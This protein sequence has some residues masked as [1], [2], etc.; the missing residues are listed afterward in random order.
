MKKNSRI[1]IHAGVNL[2]VAPMPEL[3][4]EARLSFMRRLEEIG[5]KITDTKF[6]DQKLVF[7]RRGQMPL[8]ITVGL[9]GPQFG[10]L[11]VVAPQLGNRSLDI[12]CEEAEDIAGI[13]SNIYPQRQILS[14]DATIRDLYDS[15]SEHAFKE[16]WETRLHQTPESLSAFGRPVLGGGLRFVMPSAND[17]PANP[18]IEVKI[19]SFLNDIRKIFLETQFTWNRPQPPGSL[20]DPGKRLEA[21]DDFIQD[22]VV[23]FVMGDGE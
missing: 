1:T 12:V 11:L 6:D 9:V 14:C 15:S 17:D 16:I 20:L 3:T 8:E 5:I 7:I 10:Q 21:L 18:M 2:V 19:E 13:F 22:E 4:L 23:R